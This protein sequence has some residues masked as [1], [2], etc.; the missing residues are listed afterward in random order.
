MSIFGEVGCACDAG[1]AP[2]HTHRLLHPQVDCTTTKYFLTYAVYVSLEGNAGLGINLLY[3]FSF[4]IIDFSSK[5]KERKG[6][7]Y[8]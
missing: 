5:L 4:W 3:F 8:D 7:G 1:T 6:F 2:D